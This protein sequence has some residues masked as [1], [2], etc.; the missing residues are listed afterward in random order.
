MP[1]MDTK[2][3]IHALR[4]QAAVDAGEVGLWDLR[5]ELETVHYS[6]QW[7]SRLGFPEPD[8]ADSTH[9]WRCRVHPADLEGMLAAMRAHVRGVEPMYQA[10]FRVRSNGSGY[11]LM[12]SRGRAIEWAGDGRASRMVGTMLDLTPTP[13]TPRGGLADG[14]RDM[15]GGTAMGLPFHLLLG[16]QQAG[17]TPDTA[18]FAVA[19][20]ERDR[21]LALVDDVMH[22]T[23]AQ[24]DELRTAGR[25]RG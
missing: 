18:S 7:K 14:P 25:R 13:C 11:R 20:V 23:L 3:Q 8:N 22:A 16:G 21:V 1:A 2:A 19:S 24:L 6:P 12:H 5:P 9:F 17:N 15:M 10:R 4:L